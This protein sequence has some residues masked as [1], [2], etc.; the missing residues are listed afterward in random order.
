MTMVFQIIGVV[1]L[2]A[3]Y[4]CYFGKMLRQ[5]KRGIQTDQM[6]KGKRGMVKGIELSVKFCTCFV[7]FAE[8][9]ALF[10]NVSGLPTWC[11]VAGVLLGI[12][13]MAIFILSVVTMKDS[14]RAGV[15][16]GGKTELVTNGIYSWSRNPAFLGFDLLYLGLLLMFFHWALL[17]VTAFAV[18][19]L[20]LQIV[21]VEEDFLA[22]TFGGEYVNYR[23]KVCRYFGRKG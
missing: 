2:L 15:P 17:L 12:A 6:G 5:K 22:Q 20:H 7:V 3:F 10:L 9:L 21:N 14:W 8:V 23:K 1:L 11:R 19:M 4:T 18:L 16:E 13:G